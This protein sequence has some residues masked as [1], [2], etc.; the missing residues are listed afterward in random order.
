MPDADPARA[1]PALPLTLSPDASERVQP[2]T[3]STSDAPD[4][5]P[6]PGPGG[7]PLHPAGGTG[8]PAPLAQLLTG[9]LQGLQ[10]AAAV[11]L[12]VQRSLAALL[13][14]MQAPD[15]PDHPTDGPRP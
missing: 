14:L 4:S 8:E 3:T 5:R 9:A 2:P 6:E 15:D 11:T 13:T 1:A 10:L 7:T 12:Q